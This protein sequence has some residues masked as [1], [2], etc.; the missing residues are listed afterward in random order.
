MAGEA[1]GLQL[2][3]FVP[4][5]WR[6]CMVQTWSFQVRCCPLRCH[7]SVLDPCHSLHY[8][9]LELTQG[10]VRRSAGSQGAA[11]AAVWVSPVRREAMA[12]I[13]LF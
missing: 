1:L 3:A 2:P 13:K 4:A 5:F 7:S 10:S 9:G 8:P 6:Q 12:Q 11:R